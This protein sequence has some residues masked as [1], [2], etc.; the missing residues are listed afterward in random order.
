MHERSRKREEDTGWR[1][2]T[3]VLAINYITLS[4]PL[5][6]FKVLGLGFRGSV[7]FR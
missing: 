4:L 7:G 3:K 5:L 2:S 6:V 1:G